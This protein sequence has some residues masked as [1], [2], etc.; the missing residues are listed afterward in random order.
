MLR[1]RQVGA[2]RERPAGATGYGFGCRDSGWGPIGGEDH[3]EHDGRR[4]GDDRDQHRPPVGQLRH[5]SIRPSTPIRWNP[6]ERRTVA[7]E[8]IG[9]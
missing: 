5:L 4:E 6:A 3:D 2:D 9:H 8:A 1:G 7:G